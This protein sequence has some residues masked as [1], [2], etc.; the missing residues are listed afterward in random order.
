MDARVDEALARELEL[1]Q[2]TQNREYAEA[3][4]AMK[5]ETGAG[6]LEVAGGFGIYAGPGSPMTQALSLGLFGPVV[7]ADFE[8]LEAFLGRGGPFQVEVAAIA[9]PSVEAVL[10]ARGY[11]QVE[12]Q[13]VL[14]RDLAEP[15][16]PPPPGDARVRLLER[17]EEASWSR[18]IGQAFFGQEEVPQE[19]ADLM[20]PTLR[21]P[22]NAFYGAFIGEELVGG[23]TLGRVGRVAVLSGTGVRAGFRAH[24]AQ[25]AI[26]HA[27]LEDAR[28]SGLR[29]AVSATQPD[30]GSQR[31][32]ERAGFRVA[33]PKFVYVRLP[34]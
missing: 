30:T 22:S 2:T 9:H 20:L 15:L 25:R 4:R 33:Y 3:L 29:V 31:N 10:R 1:A 26:I 13:R 32:L 19:M 23:G 28:R 6:V 21:C 16:L 14:Y 5:P 18:A 17:G 27:R 12:E 24:G 11:S 8:R 7:D 34:A